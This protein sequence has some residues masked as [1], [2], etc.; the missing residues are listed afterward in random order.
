M[1]AVVVRAHLERLIEAGVRVDEVGVLTPYNAQVAL[2]RAHLK[3]DF[4]ALEI[5]SVD[6][7]QGRE[8]E[9]MILCLVR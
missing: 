7:F 3:E 1:T 9:S 2:L 6:G 5:G 8:K 4:P